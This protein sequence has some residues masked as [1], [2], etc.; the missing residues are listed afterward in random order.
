[1]KTVRHGI[2]GIDFLN[3]N[4][5]I[6]WKESLH[7]FKEIINKLTQQNSLE[8]FAKQ[9]FGILVLRQVHSRPP[10]PPI[11]AK[12]TPKKSTQIRVNLKVIPSI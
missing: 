11:A 2:R 12:Q 9:V 1:M 3:P 7:C 5:E 4:E 6:K 8:D 10:P